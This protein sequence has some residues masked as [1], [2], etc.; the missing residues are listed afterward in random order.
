MLAPA[1]IYLLFQFG[2]AGER[3]W[4]IP[5]A[6]DIAFAVGVLVVLGRRVPIGLKIF[7]L[8]LAI[9][10]DI[11]AIVVI[12]AFYS[13][14]IQL[15][16]LGLAGIGLVLVIGMNRLGARSIVA[17]WIVGV[18]M[19]LA[20]YQSGIHPT[21]AGVAL[22]LL[23]PGRAWI[24]RDSLEAFLLDTIDRLD[25]QVDRSK[26]VGKL[27]ETARETLS[28]LE[29]LETALHSWVAFV[30]MPLF[31]LANAGVALQPEAARNGVA[32]AVAAG[33]ILGKPLGIVTFSW[34]AIRCGIAQMPAGANWRALLGVGCLG[35]IGFTMSL[36]IAGL[37][38][39]DVRLD[40]AKI[41]TFAGSVISGLAG[42]LLLVTS[43]R[44][45]AAEPDESASSESQNLN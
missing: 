16:A 37:A 38:F 27:T 44:R 40:S 18:A 30:I 20:M 11:G 36:F 2:G 1:G 41:G 13:H 3:G 33:L 29:R 31:A 45:T 39:Q 35:G 26:M 6:T 12:A 21:V 10:D 7:L 22:G 42:F 17:Y 9:V 15:V 28:P 8:A 23:T 25:G 14:E 32:W 24:A 43:L 34:I 19:W 5:M 4:G